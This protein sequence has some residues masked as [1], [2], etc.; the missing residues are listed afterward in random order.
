ML[1][2]SESAGA[3]MG[4]GAGARRDAAAAA[5][6]GAVPLPRTVSGRIMRTL[7][8]R[9]SPSQMGGGAGVGHHHYHS[10]GAGA[11]GVGAGAGAGV[12]GDIDLGLGP[13]DIIKGY[14]TGNVQFGD[15]FRKTTVLPTA[16]NEGPSAPTFAPGSP[17]DL[18]L[19]AK[20]RKK[21]RRVHKPDTLKRLQQGSQEFLR[22]QAEKALGKIIDKEHRQY[23]LS[24]GMMLG[25]YTSCGYGSGTAGP[26]GPPSSSA[27][28]VSGAGHPLGPGPG[29]LELDDFMKV[30]KLVFPPEGSSS[31][32]P[33]RLPGAFKFK[34]YAPAVF[35]QLR[36]R[37]EI[38]QQQYLKSLGGA[39]EYIEFASNSKSG[40]FFFYSHDGK[41]MIKTQSKSESKF[42]RRILAHYYNYVMMFPGTYI[43]RFYGMHRIKMPHVRKKIHFVVMQSVFYGDNEIHEMYDL[44]VSGGRGG[45]GVPRGGLEM[46]RKTREAR[47][48]RPR[49]SLTT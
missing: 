36:E 15:E 39:Y 14:R 24:F 23:H 2:R 26:A 44:K 10:G 22:K 27:L 16:A 45:A 43:T 17:L 3:W 28:A 11:G 9:T 37:F 33:H 5:D 48:T 20:L 31:T 12:G 46:M 18:A 35:Y 13:R 42:L 38:D 4:A 49:I 25:I 1:V 6:G 32:P 47:T 7:S 21:K 29:R 40:S 34:D 30:R 19:Q 8:G 41:F